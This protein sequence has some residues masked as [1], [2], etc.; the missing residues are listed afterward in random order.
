MGRSGSIAVLPDGGQCRARLCREARRRQ[1][2]GQEVAGTAGHRDANGRR[3]PN[4]IN[5][6]DYAVPL[7]ET[8]LLGNLAVWSGKK[9]QWDAKN[10]KATNA[11]ELEAVVRPTYREGYTL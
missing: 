5:F 8:V 4:G 2:I 1:G 6:V 3:D 11:P 10:L 7:T 9:V